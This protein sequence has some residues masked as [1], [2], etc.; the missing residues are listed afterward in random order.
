MKEREP[1]HDLNRGQ[2]DYG[3]LVDLDSEAA[4]VKRN[5]KL[6]LAQSSWFTNLKRNTRGQIETA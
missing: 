2:R 3:G 4:P 1:R 5:H 6:S